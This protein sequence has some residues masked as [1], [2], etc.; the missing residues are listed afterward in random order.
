MDLVIQPQKFI[1]NIFNGFLII[2]SFFVVLTFIYGRPAG[3]IMLLVLFLFLVSPWY[4]MLKSGI[5]EFKEELES[6]IE[7]F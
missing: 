3:A 1:Q 7:K 6:D 5:R 4:M 2:L